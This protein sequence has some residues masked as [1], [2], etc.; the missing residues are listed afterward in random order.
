MPKTTFAVA[1]HAG[2]VPVICP[3]PTPFSVLAAL[4]QP[5]RLRIFRLLPQREPIGV[6]ARLIAEAI[7]APRTIRFPL[8]LQF[9]FA[10]GSCAA[11]ARP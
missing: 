7:G 11:R 2:R 5:T 4:A 6:T 9:W 8:T 10:P 3:L 1:S